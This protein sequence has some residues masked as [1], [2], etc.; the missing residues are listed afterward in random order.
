[1]NNTP[2]AAVL[3]I[4]RNET[5]QPA[6]NNVGDFRAKP[7]LGSP[8]SRYITLKN[9][10]TFEKQKLPCPPPPSPVGNL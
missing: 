6:S 4:A 2:A 3:R 1:M 8:K 5:A 9:P 7:K 10:F